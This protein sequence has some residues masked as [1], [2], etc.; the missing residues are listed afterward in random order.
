MKLSTN[1][2]NILKNFADIN[3][4]IYVQKG[5]YLKTVSTLKNILAKAEVEEDFPQEF[6]IYDLNVFLGIVT[7]MSDVDL[8]FEDKCVK[9]TDTGGKTQFFYADPSIIT[10][11]PEKEIDMPETHIK[12]ELTEHTYSWLIKMATILQTPD[13]CLKGLPDEDTM[14]LSTTNRKIDTSNNYS[15]K[16]GVGVKN[17]FNIVFKKET[18]KIVPGDYDVSISS[19]GI[20]HFKHKK[21]A[22]EY[23]IALEATSDYGE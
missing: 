3:Q 1:T 12:F 8:T 20:S 4:S 2:L 7:T 9:V 5:N 14:Y 22:L 23:W 13:V 15:R 17:K 6:A 16:V 18:L 11:P 21:L 10:K 19:K